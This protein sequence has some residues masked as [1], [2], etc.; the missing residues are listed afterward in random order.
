MLKAIDISEIPENTFGQGGNRK[1]QSPSTRF[2]RKTLIDFDRNYR[3][4]QVAEVSEYPKPKRNPKINADRAAQTLRY[5]INN[6]I[7][8]GEL[9]AKPKVIVRDTRIFLMKEPSFE[10]VF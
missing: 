10:G 3:P 7:E 6:M 1:G 4:G 8:R 2:A 9:S 5:Q